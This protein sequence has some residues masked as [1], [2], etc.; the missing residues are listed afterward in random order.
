MD[1]ILVRSLDTKIEA[2]N[3][4]FRVYSNTGRRDDYSPSAIPP[5]HASYETIA[6][7][8]ICENRGEY[9]HR[10]Y[11]AFTQ[12][13]VDDFRTIFLMHPAEIPSLHDRLNK[14]LLEKENFKQKYL[15]EQKRVNKILDMTFWERIKAVFTGIKM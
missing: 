2:G 15:T 9:T 5:A 4:P 14:A 1:T 7:M 10:Q 8:M 3:Q 11:I 13:A 6:P 12:E